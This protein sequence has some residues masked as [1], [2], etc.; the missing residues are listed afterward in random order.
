M[1]KVK[2][3]VLCV[4]LLSLAAYTVVFAGTDS[5]DS[6]TDPVISLSYLNEIFLPSIR[7]QITDL[8]NNVDSRLDALESGSTGAASSTWQAIELTTG[9]ILYAKNN[10]CEILLR[11]GSA[12]VVSREADNGLVDTT[13]GADLMNGTSLPQGKLILIPRDD[14]RGIRVTYVSTWIMV[15]GEYTIVNAN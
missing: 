10:A 13:G 14:G 9:Q 15:R 7:Q 5:F 6:S 12:T 4:L 8:D 1:K 11:R 3:V 2:F